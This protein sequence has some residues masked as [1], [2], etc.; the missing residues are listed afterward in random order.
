MA[1]Q[2]AVKTISGQQSVLSSDVLGL[3]QPDT[4]QDS[5]N[6]ACPPGTAMEWSDQSVCGLIN[7]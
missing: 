6:K 1:S 5:G 2:D 3:D 4:V 7:I